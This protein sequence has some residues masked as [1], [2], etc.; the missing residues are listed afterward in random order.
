M[1]GRS[2]GRGYRDTPLGLPR[3]WRLVFPL[4]VSSGQLDFV[5]GGGG[6]RE[7][8]RTYNVLVETLRRRVTGAVSIDCRPGPGTVLTKEEEDAV[9]K[10]LISMCDMG[11]GLTR[12][13]VMNWAF[14]IVE[15]SG[16]AHPFTGESAG[17]SWFMGFIQRNP[18]LTVRTP[19]I[20]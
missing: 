11:Y 2:L 19:Q 13:I 10:Y 15:K 3:T 20:I 9:V 4:N 14:R 12:E 18:S 17:R 5:E 8:A 16:R 1:T 7:A 6:L